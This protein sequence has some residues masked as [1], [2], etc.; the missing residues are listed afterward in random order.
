MTD[1]QMRGAR[2][3]FPTEENG[4]EQP[5]PLGL[6][7]VASG[8]HG[9]QAPRFPSMTLHARSRHPLPDMR[10]QAPTW[11]TTILTYTPPRRQYGSVAPA[12][13]HCYD[14]SSPIL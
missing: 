12:T 11:K 2:R 9:D 1:V 8:G 3:R 4:C 5:P 7:F 10:L 13:K 6:Q 14:E